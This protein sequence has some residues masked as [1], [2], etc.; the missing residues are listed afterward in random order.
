MQQPIADYYEWQTRAGFSIMADPRYTPEEFLINA[1]KDGEEPLEMLLEN[2][3]AAGQYKVEIEAG[4]MQIMIEELRR[5]DTLEAVSFLSGRPGIDENALSHKIASAFSFKD[6]EELFLDEINA[7]AIALAEL[8]FQMLQQ[9]GQMPPPLNGQDHATHLKKHQEQMQGLSD[10]ITQGIPEGADPAQ[11]G[12]VLQQ[13]QTVVQGLQ[14]HIDL[15]NQ[16]L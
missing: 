14:Q 16:S 7:D 1:A 4:S 15:H 13:M 11:L 6:E 3:W 8:E 10:Q 5:N 9:T 2:W 12:P